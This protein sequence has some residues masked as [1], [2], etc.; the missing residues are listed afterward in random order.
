M[1]TRGRKKTST[2]GKK[3]HSVAV[4]M[5]P[6]GPVTKEELV[7]VRRDI[8]RHPEIGFD[9]HRTSALVQTHLKTFGLKPKVLAGTGVTALIEG[10]KQG[11]TLMMR[12]D[13]DALPILEENTYAF[14]SVND[15][16]M[17]A[18]GHDL[19]AAILLGVTKGLMKDRP[20]QGRVKLNFQPAE[21][22]LNGAGAMIHAGIMKAP[23]VDA[24]LGY[25]IW[26][27][28]PVG[29]IGV[30]KGPCMA[31][32]DRFVVTIR[33]KG[34]HAAYPQGSI[35]PVLAA[36][37]TVTALQTIVSRNINPQDAA[38]VTVGQI[39]AGTAFNIIPPEARMEGTVRTFSKEA[40]KTVPKRFKEIVS[41]VAKSLGATAVI[42]YHR[43]HNALVNNAAMSDFVR[44]VAGDVIGKKNVVD[45]E[46]SM[47]GEDHEAYQ[48]IA[49]GCYSFLGAGTRKGEAYPHHHPRFNPD[50]AVLEVGASIMTEAAR[51]WL[52]R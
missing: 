9:E 13:L 10:K 42:E 23:K 41:G 8:H 16:V 44:E 34:G 51:R 29:K 11:K 24:V 48:A 31:A 5:K 32:V 39:H 37:H 47:G 12:S 50:E 35:D 6:S 43:E 20:Q 1:S 28:I 36:A 45:T 17:H 30:V 52:A 22:G 25:H 38:V 7:A 46:P 14:K 3:T 15:G 49:P 40:G 19:H 21:E 27:E 33:G 4:L 2:A 26:Q 18:C